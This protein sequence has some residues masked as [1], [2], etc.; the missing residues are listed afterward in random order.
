MSGYMDAEIVMRTKKFH[1]AGFV[2][3]SAKAERV[4]ELLE[5]YGPRFQADF[6]ASAPIPDKPTA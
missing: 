5:S 2:L 3:R 1:H 6:A 4:K